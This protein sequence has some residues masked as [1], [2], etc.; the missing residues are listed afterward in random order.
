MAA[1]LNIGLDLLFVLVFRWGIAGAAAATVIAQ[2]VSG[3]GIALYVI[4]VDPFSGH[5]LAQAGA[6]AK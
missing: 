5:V 3:V 4:F 6:A 1:L 2:Y